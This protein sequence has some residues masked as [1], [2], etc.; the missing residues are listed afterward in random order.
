[1][2]PENHQIAVTAGPV[3]EDFVKTTGLQII[4]GEDFS[5]QDIKDVSYDDYHKNIFHF[6]LN[7]SAAKEPGWP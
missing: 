2:M 1:M 5:L 7:E 4:A 3:D 6:I